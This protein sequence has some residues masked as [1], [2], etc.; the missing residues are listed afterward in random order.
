M[1]ERKRRT[2]I[3]SA[4]FERE[5]EGLVGEARVREVLRGVLWFLERCPERGRKA[6]DAEIWAIP[7]GGRWGVPKLVFFYFFDEEEVELE[8]VALVELG[9]PGLEDD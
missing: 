6:R 5:L 7:T 8:S 4:R 3:R 1:S 2:I 9:D